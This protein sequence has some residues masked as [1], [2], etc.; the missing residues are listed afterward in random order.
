[1][2]IPKFLILA[3]YSSLCARY[4]RNAEQTQMLF[5]D[6]FTTQARRFCFFIFCITLIKNFKE[7]GY[8]FKIVAQTGIVLK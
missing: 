3:L 1:M 7:Q 8:T 6:L 2:A 5:H 4:L